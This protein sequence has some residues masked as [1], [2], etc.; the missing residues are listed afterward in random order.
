MILNENARRLEAVA[1]TI[2][3]LAIITAMV[4]AFFKFLPD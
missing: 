3:I 2:K 1:R 4:L